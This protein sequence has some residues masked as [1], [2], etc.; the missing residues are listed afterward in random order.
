MA[1]EFSP[2]TATLNGQ[3]LS[4]VH[5]TEQ[6]S[7]PLEEVRSAEL[8]A[9]LPKYSRTVGTGMSSLCEGSFQVKGYGGCRVTFDPRQASFIILKTEDAT[10]IF[11]LESPQETK[12]C[13]DR[14][15]EGNDGNE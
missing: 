4:V 1:V 15:Q 13:Y 3:T 9:A 12:A 14:I 2:R 5:V 8:L 11:N 6:F 7:V 10:Y